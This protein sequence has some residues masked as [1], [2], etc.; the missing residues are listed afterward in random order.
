MAFGVL[1]RVGVAAVGLALC[2]CAA[3]PER[4]EV[5]T[6]V[7]DP[8]RMAA[9][10]G[11]PCAPL[12]VEV[13]H[14]R[15]WV[16]PARAEC[17]HRVD[18]PPQRPLE[19]R[20]TPLVPE[21]DPGP[22]TFRVVVEEGGARRVVAEETVAPA[23]PSTWASERRTVV[24]A[25][26]GPAAVLLEVEGD[27]SSDG[28]ASA[29]WGSPLLAAAEPW[30]RPNLVLI[31][32]DTLRSDHMSLYGYPKP[33]TPR[34]DAWAQ[35]SGVV[36]ESAVASSPWTLPSHATML[37]GRDAIGHGAN[38]DRP[39]PDGLELVAERLRAHGYH[40]HAVTGGGWLDTSYGLDRGFDAYR[41]FGGSP[42]DELPT[43]MP[44]VIRWL[45]SDP[46]EPFFLFF[47]T[48]EVHEPFVRRGEDGAVL[49]DREIRTRALKR[50]PEE[51]F[52]LRR[53]F[54][55]GDRGTP[56][57]SWDRL[58]DDDLPEVIAR[59]DSGIE[60]AD[61]A[62]GELLATLDRLDLD[63]RTVVVLTSD[64]GEALGER[65][66]ASHA[67]LYDFNLLVPLVIAAPTAGWEAGRVT[68]QVRLAD[69]VPTLLDLAGLLIPGDLDGVSMRPIVDGCE[70]PGDR[71]AWSYAASSNRGVSIRTA[72]GG[73]YIL[74]NTAWRPLF[75][76]EE[77][78]GIG[79]DSD[80]T[81][82]LG[83][84]ENLRRAVV[85][86]MR[87]SSPGT[88]IEIDNPSSAALRVRL[89]SG[90]ARPLYLK[91]E[92]VSGRGFRWTED[93]AAVGRLDPGESCFLHS[94]WADPKWIV[95]ELTAETDPPARFEGRVDL[96]GPGPIRWSLHL[97]GA[98]WV[99]G[100]APPPGA[101]AIA[102][103]TGG[104]LDTVPDLERTGE[105]RERLRALGYVE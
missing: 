25:G 30:Q 79:S 59:Y 39:V 54:I 3:A 15:R 26:S 80:E 13:D 69:I 5:P 72:D 102:V 32:I 10:D 8:V 92:A 12:Q 53:E 97:D 47:H 29:G 44:M 71:D 85:A 19:L 103:S 31:S 63:E 11:S 38:Y 62:I 51:G 78:Y 34:I 1:G 27:G 35:E 84:D 90:V 21:D 73:K 87:R 6:A 9:A 48:Y 20:W 105:M 52:L 88:R 37:S 4:V 77:R 65:G 16:L 89:K 67:Y 42:S 98:R 61:R 40:T 64:H 58:P 86:R 18:L 96:D 41:Y 50:V 56:H 93:G 68:H 23:N 7:H 57:E 70:P 22:V 17:V 49:S 91:A 81:D 66:L 100:G 36:F 95:V 75:G 14:E 24:D 33:T 55:I 76:R 46:V 74:N 43:Q 28:G 60:Y 82:D 83:P 45:E 101:P 2:G 104:A 94:E 99:E